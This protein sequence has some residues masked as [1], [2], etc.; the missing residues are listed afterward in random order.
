[1]K[2]KRCPT[3]GRAY[4]DETLSFCL[5]DGAPLVYDPQ[6][7]TAIFSRGDSGEPAT[8]IY[9]KPPAEAPPKRAPGRTIIVTAASVLVLLGIGLAAYL[10]WDRSP[11]RKIGSIAVLPLRNETG[12]PENEYLP[13]GITEL[14]ISKLSQLPHLQVKA[15]SSVFRYKGQDVQP[16]AVASDLNVDSIL[17][18]RFARSGERYVFSLE[19]VDART[20]NV[21][22]SEQYIREPARLT[23]VQNEIARDVADKLRAKL[24]GASEL[25]FER[26]DTSDQQAYENYLRGRFHWN[27][28]SREGLERAIEYFNRAVAADPAYARAYSG[29]AET[30]ALMPFYA[31]TLADD[32]FAKAKAAA[33]KAIEIDPNLAE[34]YTVLGHVKTWYDFDAAGA[35]R[36]FRRAIELD[37]NY[38]TGH[39]WYALFLAL[40]ERHA[41]ASAEMQRAF[42]LDPFSVGINLDVGVVHYYARRYGEA[43]VQLRRTLEMDPNFLQT[44]LF[45]AETMEQRRQY[46]E[47]ADAW[48]DVVKIAGG[49]PRIIE[50]LKPAFRSGGELGF[51]REKL[52]ILLGRWERRREG[53]VAI[54][55]VYAR[56]G[57]P[58]K[59]FEW[60]DRA[61]EIRELNL[62]TLRVTPGFDRIRDDPRFHVH[63]QR[64]GLS[65]ADGQNN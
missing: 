12:S 41:E 39:H 57:E 56:L 29:L 18:G 63:L 52:K 9:E 36:D 17:T 13:D 60:L 53:A 51:Y 20:E 2:A 32:S 6:Q 47:A 26:R 54:A 30:Y 55:E 61:F 37:P 34:P 19:L 58:G 42:D 31:D 14:L 46:E 21:I 59:A 40:R 49:D 45:Y 33:A 62:P 16:A 23:D 64:T 48:V 24:S 38:S 10:F 22:W 25:R 65:K 11:D 44:H 3:C 50:A 35:E 27:K 1:M 7:A 8:R 28:R 5:E 43:E 15:R 4:I